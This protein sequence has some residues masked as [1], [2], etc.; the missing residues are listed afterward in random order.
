MK[1]K[2]AVIIILYYSDKFNFKDISN[3]CNH[4]VI[5]VDNTPSRN[6]NIIDKNIYYIPLNKNNGISMAQNIGLSKAME[7]GCSFAVF[8]D[9]DSIINKEYIDGIVSEYQRISF[10]VNNI[11]LLGPVVI[12]GRTGLEY[13]SAIHTDHMFSKD[14]IYRREIIS[15]GSCVQISKV[16]KVGLLKNELF[17]DYVDF[18]WCWRANRM[19]FVSGITPRIKLQ[20]LVGQNEFKLFGQLVI[21][22]SPIRYF[23]QYRNYLWLLRKRYVPFQWKRNTGI[24]FLLRLFYFPFCIKNWKQI[25]YNMWRGIWYGLFKYERL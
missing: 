2:I 18:E 8:F 15:S 6:L 12:N 25:E 7:L 16:R 21:I 10:S 14:F 4:F 13:K 9:Q 20:H 5:L 24:K 11:F 22:S 23:Y 1:I 17:I 3:D 19:G